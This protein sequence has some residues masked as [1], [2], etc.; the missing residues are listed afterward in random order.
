MI[1]TKSVLIVLMLLYVYPSIADDCFVQEERLR[2]KYDGKCENGLAH[3]YAVASGKD[4]YKGYFNKGKRHGEGKQVDKKKPLYKSQGVTYYEGGRVYT[5]KWKDDKE[6]GYGEASWPPTGLALGTYKGNWKDGS[7]HGYGE[8]SHGD[9]VYKGNWKHGFTDGKGIMVRRGWV[10]KGTFGKYEKMNGVGELVHPNGNRYIGEFIN[11]EKIGNGV[12]YLGN[13]VRIEGIWNGRGRLSGKA[14]TYWPNG[15]TFK[16][17]WSDN[18]PLGFGG[19][20]LFSDGE[21][22]TG[23]L[24]EVVARRKEKYGENKENLTQSESDKLVVLG[25]VALLSAAVY[26]LITW[27]PS[28][29]S[30]SSSGSYSNNYSGSSNT[31]NQADSTNANSLSSSQRNSAAYVT[32]IKQ[33]GS[34]TIVKCSVGNDTKIYRKYGKC[35]DNYK[36][37]SYSCESVVKWA[38]DRCNNR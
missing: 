1:Y 16:G 37:G 7:R 25:T 19:E 10:Y 4:E 14:T 32:D 5:G 6:N 34:T 9:V 29:Y 23:D 13:G 38:R 21:R 12:I 33:D 24:Y 36:F 3:G 18:E 35:S 2:G 31:S 8:S 15:D 17:N 28:N 22:L 11:N 27:T 30:D 26:K 20:A